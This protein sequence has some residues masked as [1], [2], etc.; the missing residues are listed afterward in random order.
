MRRILV[1]FFAVIGALVFAVILTTLGLVLWSHMRGP[2]IADNTVLSIDISSSFPDAPPSS[3]LSTLINPGRPLLRDVLDGLEKATDDP[4]VTGLV[5]RFGD[6]EIG[7]AEAQEL[8]D[9]ILRF[10]AK[11]KRAVA[12]ADSFGEFSSGTR[13]YYL[14]SAFDDIWVQPLGMVGLVG[15][16][17]EE[18]FFRGTLDLLGIVPSFDH[19]EQYKSAVDPLTQ[20]AM[21]DPD[22]EQI[23]ALL[24]SVYGQIVQ[25]IAASRKIDESAVRTLVDRG[26]ILANEALDA[27]LI[28]HVGYSDEALG[29]LGLRP[30]GDK[31]P[32]SLQRYLAAVGHPH[33]SGPEIALIYANGLIARGGGDNSLLGSGE[34]GADAVIRAFRLAERDPQVRAI[35]FRIDSPGGSAVASE[36]IWRETLRAKEAGKKLVV[37]MGDV[38]GS[39]GYYIAASAD[40][41]VADPATLTGSIGVLAGKFVLGGLLDKIGA[42][43]SAVEVGA[44]AGMFSSFEDFT[45][46]EHQRFETF[47]DDVYTG[48]KDRVAQGRKMDAE[49]VEAVAKGRIWS[50]EDAKAKGLVDAL[51]GYDT[52][53]A[54]AKQEA[55]IP[56]TSDVTVK[57]FPPPQSPL[58]V[59]L[60]RLT[61]RPAPGSTEAMLDRALATLEPLL[62][63]LQWMSA[64]GALTMAPVE[65]R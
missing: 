11:G 45:P 50:G 15:L 41:I 19:R 56:P 35:L 7:L 5:A 24:N 60:A 48:F 55:G 10:R 40:K 59:L 57:I 53:L 54:L 1:G 39:G 18:P 21:T 33:R 26:P 62:V 65:V 52:A 38:A 12:Y 37:S 8:R 16:R 25:G 58:D 2:T 14:A 42:G 20:K 34:A 17:A 46:A 31:E 3:A 61:G 9:A 51:G 30:R 28:T 29:T 22:R 27:H 63:R 6:G 43:T 49:A 64:P 23:G 32:V 44:N 13:S 47:L 36:S 4:R